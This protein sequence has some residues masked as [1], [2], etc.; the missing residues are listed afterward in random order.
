[1][2]RIDSSFLRQHFS[3]D[4][5]EDIGT[6][7]N[8]NANYGWEQI[9]NAVLNAR[10]ICSHP[11][12]FPKASFDYLEQLDLEGTCFLLKAPVQYLI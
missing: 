2:I 5:L 6:G 12:K 11:E 1:M 4:F 9:R 7:M 8:A 10:N 3:A